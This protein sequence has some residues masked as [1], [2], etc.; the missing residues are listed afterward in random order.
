MS[1]WDSHARN[2]WVIRPSLPGG[3]SEQKNWTE[4]NYELIVAH[5]DILQ[6]YLVERADIYL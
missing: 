2:D 1:E 5:L 6:L 3:Q 4:N